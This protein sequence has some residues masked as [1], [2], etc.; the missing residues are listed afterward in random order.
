MLNKNEYFS[1]LHRRQCA[2]NDEQKHCQNGICETNGSCIESGLPGSSSIKRGC[3]ANVTGSLAFV[4]FSSTS[5]LFRS[6][7]LYCAI[8]SFCNDGSINWLAEG[9]C[10]TPKAWNWPTLQKPLSPTS[11]G[12]KSCVCTEGDDCE[13]GICKLKTA[14]QHHVCYIKIVRFLMSPTVAALSRGCAVVERYSIN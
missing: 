14:N 8:G 1:G 10:R 9:L 3:Y 7:T 12:P 2:C 6:S 11:S 4:K 13:N 5:G